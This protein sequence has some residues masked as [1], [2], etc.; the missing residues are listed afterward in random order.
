MKIESITRIDV[1]FKLIVFCKLALPCSENIDC[2][3][4]VF[5]SSQDLVRI[6][7]QTSMSEQK[8]HYDLQKWHFLVII[9]L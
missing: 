6:D 3:V 1:H 8:L 5:F 2:I 9:I 4:P 7:I